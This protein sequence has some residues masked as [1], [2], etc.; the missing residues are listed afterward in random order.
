MVLPHAALLRWLAAL[1]CAST[2]AVAPTARATYSIVACDAQGECGVAVATH[3]LAVGASVPYARA[4]VGAVVSQYETNLAYGPKALDLM[5]KGAAPE[6]ALATLLKEDSDDDGTTIADRQVGMVDAKGRTASY[7]GANAAQASWAGELHGDRYAVQGNGLAGERVLAAMKEAFLHAQGALA[8]RLMS[9][10]EAGQAAGGQT[11]GMMS[12][13]LLVRT[14]DGAWQDIDLRVDGSASPITDLR[15]LLD[16]HDAWQVMIRAE[17]QAQAGDN[18]AAR[19]SIAQALQRS[20]GWDRIWRRAAR[21]AMH[22]GDTHQALVYLA[23]FVSINP[24]W[25]RQE[26]RDDLYRPLRGNQQFDA[27]MHAMPSSESP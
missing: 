22:M 3:H 10:L 25:A 16:Q 12:A 27:W 19:Q 6:A 2:L 23:T 14:P 24:V 20:H 15:R 11:I 7:T 17:H 26:L 13:A 1:A 18:A 4:R 9:A 21:L 5:A 8:D